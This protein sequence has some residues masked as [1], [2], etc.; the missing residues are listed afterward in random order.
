MKAKAV[1]EVGFVFSLTL[2]LVALVGLSPIG[3][4]ERQVT[5]QFFIE[6]AV[7][8]AVPLLL[9]LVTRR[10]LSA[11]GLSLRNPRY[12]L[13]IAATA[14][15]PV[16]FGILPAAF[17]DY[18]SWFGALIIAGVQIAVLFAVGWLLRR[19]PT[20]NES[21]VLVGAILLISRLNLTQQATLGNSI[22]AFVF[23]LFFLAFGEELLFR[24]YIQSR[25]NVAWGRPFQFFGTNW[26]WGIVIM[27]LLFGLM[28]FLNLGS[29]AIGNWQLEPWWGFW[30]FFGGLVL[31]FVREKTGSIAASTILHG[32]PDALYHAYL[33]T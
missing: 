32:L 1:I 10:N 31:G 28:H 15:V 16:V 30:T 8:I 21:G 20:M 7:M 29:L 6:Y 24:G 19:K 25:L 11:Y 12:H 4:W 14:I 27:S 33:G 22:S 17:V 13:N 9:L 5:N 2:F 26:G 18:T 3:E 23:Y